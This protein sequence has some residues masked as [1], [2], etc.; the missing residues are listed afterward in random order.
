MKR[1]IGSFVLLISVVAVVWAENPFPKPGLFIV[2]GDQIRAYKEPKNVPKKLIPL[3]PPSIKQQSPREEELIPLIEEPFYQALPAVPSEGRAMQRH[4]AEPE[5][6]GG[7]VSIIVPQRISSG[8]CRAGDVLKLKLGKPI[9]D[10]TGRIFIQNDA[11]ILATVKASRG[12]GLFSRRGMINISLDSAV[13]KFGEKIPL[14][15]AITRYGGGNRNLTL[16]GAVLVAWP[17]SF[18]QGSNAVIGSGTSLTADV[19]FFEP[20]CAILEAEE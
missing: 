7:L 9:M 20:P 16:A 14:S 13:G 4:A 15:G 11:Q 3:L 2:D 1:Y 12:G 10:R 19:R 18:L 17:L 8:H 5:T 6:A